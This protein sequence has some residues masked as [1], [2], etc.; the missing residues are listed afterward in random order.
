MTAIADNLPYML[1]GLTYTMALSIAAIIGSFVLGS[2]L[3]VCRLSRSVLVR[4]PA[5]TFIE[6]VRTVPLLLFI[7]FT[8]FILASLGYNISAF[9]S[10]C[11]ALAV[12][13]SAYVAE[14]IRG[15]ILGIPP[16]QLEAA[17]ASGLSYSQAML[18]IILPQAVR[19]MMPA[20][21]SEFIMLIKETSL[22]SVIGVQEFFSRVSTTNAR[23]MVHPI[24]LISFAAIIYFCIC[25]GLSVVSRS[26]EERLDQ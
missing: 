4:S 20:L 16:G 6:L 18:H 3:A 15:G 9:L 2:L 19:R 12:F 21:T 1:L 7:F 25:F 23:V 24:E 10:G 26:F 17:Q 8:Y 5:I 11:I 13:A 14:I 22:V